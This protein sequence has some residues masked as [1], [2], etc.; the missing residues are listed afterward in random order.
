M[1]SPDGKLA[2]S[3]GSWDKTLKL[4]DVATGLEVRT[5][6]GHSNS[7]TS[8]AFSPDGKLALSGCWDSTLKL[9]DVVTGLEVR[10]FSGHSDWVASVAFSPD[11]KL[12]L[13][14][15]SDQTLKLWDVLTGREVRTFT[16]HSSSVLSVAFSPDGK[17]ALSGGLD[18]TLKL[19]DVATGLAV[20]T[21]TGHSDCVRSVAFSLDGK[22]ALSGSDDNTVRLWD[23][24]TGR[25][26]QTSRSPGRPDAR[27][28]HGK[29][30]LARGP[31][32]QFWI[33][34][35]ASD[36]PLARMIHFDDNEWVCL[37][38]EGY[39]TAST[40]GAKHLNV[41]LGTGNNVVPMEG[42]YLKRFHRP[43][44]VQKALATP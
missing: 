33:H 40:N 9:W 38:P 16:G 32:P 22:L 27:S 24:A 29:H 13:S 37:T 4:W 43:D 17:L 8:V 3:S 36:A 2:L 7:V 12:A 34:S 6:T 42:E 5:F 44:L 10:T 11:G 18:E 23:A 41:R 1:F 19:W 15:S 21:F 20:R 26:V 35:L 30:F 28:L 31:G 25:L 39:F 14:G